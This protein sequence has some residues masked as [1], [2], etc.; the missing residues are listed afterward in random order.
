M[1][2]K[3][4]KNTLQTTFG[5]PNPYLDPK[6]RTIAPTYTHDMVSIKY[7][8]MHDL[9]KVGMPNEE[10]T[11]IMHESFNLCTPVKHVKE[12]IQKKWN[13]PVKRQVL[14]FHRS[15]K[16]TKLNDHDTLASYGITGGQTLMLT[17]TPIKLSYVERR[18]KEEKD[19]KDLIIKNAHHKKI[20]YTRY[21]NGS[22]RCMNN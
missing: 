22:I 7:T 18:K 15:D 4:P 10:R 16:K 9:S 6:S 1:A 14:Y 21:S 2:V 13:H 8:Y 12:A 20:S 19:A 17:V 3:A 5:Q 11:L